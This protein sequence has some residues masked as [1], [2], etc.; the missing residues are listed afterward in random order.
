MESKKHLFAS[1]G[2][3]NGKIRG[4]SQYENDLSA[5]SARQGTLHIKD[6]LD[7][8]R[9]LALQTLSMPNSARDHL[10]SK[11]DILL[12]SPSYQQY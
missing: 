2:F 10:S 7:N 8:N 4:R 9:N 12:H 1:L 11:D 6:M 5:V 3:T